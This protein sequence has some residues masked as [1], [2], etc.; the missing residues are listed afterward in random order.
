MSSAASLKVILFGGENSGK[1]TALRTHC[2]LTNP[3]SYIKTIGIDYRV[4]G[5]ELSNGR[6]Y[7]TQ[8]WDTAGQERFRVITYAYLKGSDG[9]LLFYSVSDRKSFE[10]ISSIL[11]SVYEYAGRKDIPLML[12][13]TKI[14]NNDDREVT[15]YEG[16]S[17]ARNINKP[18]GI[19]FYEI[20]SKTNYG[21]DEAFLH[22]Y[23]M[24]AKLIPCRLSNCTSWNKE[25]HPMCIKDQKN[26][27]KTML[28]HFQS[29]QNCKLPNDVIVYIFQFLPAA[30][31]KFE[32]YPLLL[33]QDKKI[34][35]DA[36]KSTE[37]TKEKKGWFTR[38]F[39]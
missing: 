25:L 11:P 24:S 22:M 4:K 1:T 34:K 21:V 30:Q 23:E 39:D 27:L 28:L 12:V 8:I 31:H 35:S 18:H 19:P 3:T 26:I 13:G 14:D 33:S 17:L 9:V 10:T 29:L 5:V 2:G 32:W 36:H 38:W 16:E 7:K 20:S 37:S 6:M 15:H